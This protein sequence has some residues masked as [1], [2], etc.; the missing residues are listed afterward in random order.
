ML[1]GVRTQELNAGY[2]KGL[3]Q[4]SCVYVPGIKGPDVN[5][6]EKWLDETSAAINFQ[7]VDCFPFL[8]P[9]YRLAPDWMIPFKAALR[10]IRKLENRVFFELLDVV[11]ANV[12][13]GKIYP[14]KPTT[15]PLSY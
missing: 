8:R 14:S 2:V 11:K 4:V 13:S 3:K 12:K 15:S 9:I 10:D 1:Y 7:P 6:L 5:I